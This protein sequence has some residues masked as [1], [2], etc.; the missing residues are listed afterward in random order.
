MESF[1]CPKC[2]APIQYNSAEQGY[3]ETIPCPFCGESIIVPQELRRPPAYQAGTPFGQDQPAPVVIDL[4]GV[5]QAEPFGFNTTPID[6]E[7]IGKVAK[8]TVSGVVIAIIVFTCISLVAAFA[9]FQIAQNTI[10]QSVQSITN[11]LEP[12]IAQEHNPT[13]IYQTAVANIFPTEAPT[14]APPTPAYSPTPRINHTATAEAEATRTAQRGL[15]IDQSN[16]PIVL[17][18]KFTAPSK[19]WNSGTDNNE[20]ALE[21]LT[22][23]GGKYTWKYTSKQSMGSFSYPTMPA[24]TD[25]YVSVDMQMTSRTGNSGNQAGIIFRDS[26]KDQTFYF[27]AISPDGTYSLSMYDGKE[28]QDMLPSEQTDLFKENQVNHL[29]V[30][31]QDSQILLILNNSVI[32]SFEDSRLA[33]G[34]AGLGLFLAGPGEDATVIF[35]NF[36]VRAPKSK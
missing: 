32:N 25:M 16:W 29:A 4:R 28:W 23:A 6:T 34:G 18:E 27:F 3:K 15:A 14:I 30:S 36:Y 24:Q 5:G 12:A 13:E 7:E 10:R 26:D 35:S 31:M 9:I 1:D 8:R 21:V 17:Q 20:Y 19:G 33:S 22:I 11:G 2:G